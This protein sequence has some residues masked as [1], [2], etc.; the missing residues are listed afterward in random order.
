MYTTIRDYQRLLSGAQ[1][2]PGSRVRH[3]LLS[4]HIALWTL[5]EPPGCG[6]PAGDDQK[7][8]KRHAGTS[9]AQLAAYVQH[10]ADRVKARDKKA[11]NTR[12]DPCLTHYEKDPAADG[13]PGL[14]VLEFDWY[15]F[16]A[17]IRFEQHTEYFAIST[18]LDLSSEEGRPIY[19]EKGYPQELCELIDE[20]E[21]LESTFK[22]DTEVRYN[23]DFR[24]N[25]EKIS[26]AA[27]LTIWKQFHSEILQPEDGDV[28]SLGRVFADFRGI[29]LSDDIKKAVSRPRRRASRFPISMLRRAGR[30]VPHDV[31]GV[32]LPFWRKEK[33]RRR[34]VSTPP[35]ERAQ[36]WKERYDLL[37]PLM[38]AKMG[39]IDL[40]NYEFTAS[41]MGDG[42]ALYLSALGAQPVPRKP[43]EE[44]IPL[45]YG[46]YTH[47]LG[48]W[49]TGRL[50]EQLH[51]QGTLRLASLVDLPALQNAA[52]SL[53]E[54]ESE[55]REAYRSAVLHAE[56]SGPEQ[57]PGRRE[58]EEETDKRI[59]LIKSHVTRIETELSQA[60]TK[61]GGSVEQRIERARYYIKRFREGLPA[62]QIEQFGDMQPYGVF[63]ERRLGPTFGYIDMLWSRYDRIRRDLRALYQRLLAEETKNVTTAIR[64]CNTETEAIHKVAD[65]ALFAVLAPYYVGYILWY[66]FFPNRDHAPNGMWV[67]L[68]VA[69]FTVALTRL[70]L[71]KWSERVQRGRKTAVRV[72]L[73]GQAAFLGLLAWQQSWDVKAKDWLPSQENSSS[74]P[75][76]EK[77]GNQASAHPHAIA[78][79]QQGK[80]QAN[81]PP[82]PVANGVSET[83][84]NPVALRPGSQ[85]SQ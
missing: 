45:C 48:G 30:A 58:D 7:T 46:L 35:A 4:W 12:F 81:R 25:F 23:F 63:V 56:K 79:S 71:K 72:S 49:A 64:N 68:W 74:V 42:R 55:V 5:P 57:P 11:L 50:I 3:P 70:D 39:G 13:H 29:V 60:D 8:P 14:V 51:Q 67:T 53:R 43:E 85:R 54:A 20:I 31:F 37:W 62:L 44:R 84:D 82:E 47:Q 21:K 76:E 17:V 66:V 69:F 9:E 65:L 59:A 61:V 33:T 80:I 16:R 26:E 27:F 34:A 2:R 52:A 38:T 77:A 75:I 24:N 36:Y 19:C 41:M 1:N 28:D 32:Q 83:K 10:V 6:R 15:F 40:L 22:V 73:I 18:L 78:N